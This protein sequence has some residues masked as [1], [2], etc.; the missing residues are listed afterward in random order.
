MLFLEVART[1]NFGEAAKALGLSR[2]HLS[3]QIK[4]LESELKTPLLIRT[5]RSVRLTLEG[6]KAYVQAMGIRNQLQELEQQLTREK[7]QISGLLRITAPKMFAESILVNLCRAFHKQHPEIRFDINSSYQAY[8]L[9]EQEIDI[10]FRASRNPPQNMV[11]NHLFDY[12]H[13]LVAAPSYLQRAGRLEHPDDLADH[14][15]LAT[16]NQPNWVLKDGEIHASGWL[17]TNDN[18]VLKERAMAGDGIIRIAQYYVENELQRG[19][20]VEVMREQWQQA[21]NSIYMLYPQRI[22]PSAKQQAF[23]EFAKEYCGQRVV[24]VDRGSLI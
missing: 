23:V 12:S 3:E 11:A 5:T 9:A 16:I 8:N 18:R 24:G 2:S 21:Y 10:A 6:E 14:Q 20:L 7:N 4:R 19:E 13:A 22:Y 15:C 17:T 1:L